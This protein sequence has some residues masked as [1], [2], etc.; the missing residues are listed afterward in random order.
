MTISPIDEKVP[1]FSSHEGQTLANRLKALGH[2]VRLEIIS[3]LTTLGEPCC[4][5]VCDCLPLAQ[6]TVSQ[7]LEI[8]RKAGLII[9]RQSGN[10]S[11]FSIDQNALDSVSGA[12]SVLG[13]PRKLEQSPSLD[14]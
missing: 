13:A 9:S 11:C 5:D 14:K 7:H 1:F 3:R 8:L 2:P 4:G 6:S 10:R 12:L